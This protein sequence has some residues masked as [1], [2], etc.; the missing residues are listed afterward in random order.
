MEIGKALQAA[1]T[2]AG[3]SQGQLAKLAD[4]DRSY[5]S[6]VENNHQSPTLF[7]FFKLCRALDVKPSKLIRQIEQD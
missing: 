4:V 2:K 3:L 6:L 5:I 1:R 7:V